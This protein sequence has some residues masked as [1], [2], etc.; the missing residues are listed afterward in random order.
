M[1]QYATVL[2]TF[3][4]SIEFIIDD[5]RGSGRWVGE[6][7][8]RTPSETPK[9]GKVKIH[10][11]ELNSEPMI[12]QKMLDD[13]SIDIEAWLSDKVADEFSLMENTSYV[14]GDGNEKPKGFTVYKPWA[15]GYERD[16]LEQIT[17]TGTAGQLDKAD[18]IKN[19]QIALHEIYQPNAI[20]AMNRKTWGVIITLKDDYGRYLLDPNSFKVGDTKILLGSSVAFFADMQDIANNSLSVAYGDF[21]TGY[22]VVDR[23]G[24]RVLPDPYTVKPYTIYSTTKRT[25]G[26]LINYQSIKLLKTK[27][28]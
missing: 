27:A 4:E 21:K 23:I 19:L 22:A 3:S 28:S 11:H 10:T 15:S 9:F 24:I 14:S 13:S 25:G 8:T 20:W 6:T 16:A 26:G 5:Q 17:S 1:R 12:S 7:Q 2:N 18:D